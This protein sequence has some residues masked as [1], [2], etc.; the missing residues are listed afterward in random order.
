MQGKGLLST[1]ALNVMLPPSDFKPIFSEAELIP[2]NVTPF[3]PKE[4]SFR[5]LSRFTVPP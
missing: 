2:S 5:N 1:S 4:H 3:L